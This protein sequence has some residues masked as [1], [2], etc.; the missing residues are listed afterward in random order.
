M[1]YAANIV[2][3]FTLIPWL[4]SSNIVLSAVSSVCRERTPV[5]PPVREVDGLDVGP[6]VGKADGEDAGPL[7]G[8]AA[9]LDERPFVG[10]T[11]GPSL[12]EEL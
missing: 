4:F 12:S 1:Q 7:L 3:P 11:V 9:G 10:E 8:E 2:S 5:G 6:W